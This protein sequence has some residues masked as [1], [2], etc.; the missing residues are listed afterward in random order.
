VAP[1][2]DAITTTP[3]LLF[4]I[5]HYNLDSSHQGFRLRCITAGIFHNKMTKQEA[6]LPVCLPLLKGP[7][8]DRTSDEQ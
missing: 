6:F 5:G 4:V 3:R 1:I 2:A 7:A 8:L